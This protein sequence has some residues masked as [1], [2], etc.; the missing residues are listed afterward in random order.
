MVTVQHVNISW[1]KQARGGQLATLRNSIPHSFEI[2]QNYTFKNYGN[3]IDVGYESSHF[4]ENESNRFIGLFANLIFE[5]VEHKLVVKIPKNNGFYKIVATLSPNES[6]QFIKFSKM[7]DYDYYT[8]YNKKVLNLVFG[9][10]LPPIDI[11]T[12]NPFNFKFD[13]KSIIWK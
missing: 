12:Q 5:I 3:S 9:T 1:G 4:N 2:S 11:F 8:T 7:I 10:S 6:I 13:D